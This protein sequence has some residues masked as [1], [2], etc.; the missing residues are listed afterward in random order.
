[1]DKDMMD[2]DLADSVVKKAQELGA[3]YAEAR[4]EGF[5][6][7]A[8]LMKNDTPE[9]SDF[10]KSYGI[11]ARFVV[12]GAM[13]FMSINDLKK[14]LV[15]KRVEETIRTIKAASRM[16]KTPVKFAS[17]PTAKHEWVVHQKQ[18]LE[19]VDPKDKMEY[20]FDVR[21]AIKEVDGTQSFL[22]LFESMSKKYYT[23]SEGSMIY[24]ETPRVGLFYLLTVASNGDSEQRMLEHG[25]SGGWENVK[26]WNTIY[27]VGQEVRALKAVIERG[28]PAPKGDIKLVL[29]PELVGILVHE[30]CGHPT[31]ADRIMG[32]EAAQAGESF[33]SKEW[34]GK[35]IGN[36][37]VTV[38]EDPTIPG[39]YGF[40]HYDDEGVK[41]RR[42]FLIKDGK[43]NEF[44]H[45]RQT[46]AMM[47]IRSNGAAR[48]VFYAREP[49]VRM[50]NT[51]MMPGKHSF[52]D[53]I[54]DVKLGVYMKSFTEWNID[55]RRWNQRY[56][57]CES[58][59]IE[60]GEI[61]G[62]V[63]RPVFEITTPGFYERVE[64]CGKD[65]S[66]VAGECGKGEPM[67]GLPVWMGGPHIR[68]NDVRLG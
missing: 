55:D 39:S 27:N 15:M 41:A 49:I 7:S 59:L 67:Q 3:T 63:R 30:C 24:S 45:N 34:L 65:V 5:D 23:N 21:K 8:F 44:L 57:G 12:N 10:R 51:F 36:E 29:S 28:K 60:K 64:A 46:A 42:R 26:K 9:I 11:G 47:G 40:Y 48:S 4:L 43:I 66:Y 35:K 56:V 2:R 62:P 32:R 16:L 13:G 31:E 20:L 17:E 58:Y 18:K 1:M 53:L 25:A 61:K 14:A 50:A 68:L 54:G 37:V 33:L 19:D 6:M 38:A 22:Q 52:E